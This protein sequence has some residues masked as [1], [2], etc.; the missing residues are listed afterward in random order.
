MRMT[1]SVEDERAFSARRDALGEQ[2]ARW[3]SRRW[4]V[5]RTTR[6]C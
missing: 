6:G 2:F 4:P 3:L 5:T 1:F